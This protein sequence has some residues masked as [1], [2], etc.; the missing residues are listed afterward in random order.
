MAFQRIARR[1]PREA[2][3]LTTGASLEDETRGDQAACSGG[4]RAPRQSRCPALESGAGRQRLKE[5]RRCGGS[6]GPRRCLRRERRS[7]VA[8]VSLG[9]RRVETDTPGPAARKSH[10][11]GSF[12]RGASTL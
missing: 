5:P 2:A 3:D 6:L 8:G 9:S 4:V 7:L 11:P 12:G 1:K 10:F